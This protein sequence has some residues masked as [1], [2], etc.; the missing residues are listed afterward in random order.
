M[1]SMKDI[2]AFIVNFFGIKTVSAVVFQYK[3]AAEKFSGFFLGR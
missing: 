3:K 2:M 1:Q